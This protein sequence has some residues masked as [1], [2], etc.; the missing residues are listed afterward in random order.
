M[1]AGEGGREGKGKT[2]DISSSCHQREPWM[3][4]GFFIQRDCVGKETLI[5]YFH[6]NNVNVGGSH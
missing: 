6:E 1:L 4:Y 3:N 5:Q 2:K